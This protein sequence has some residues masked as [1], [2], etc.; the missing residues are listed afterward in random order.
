MYEQPSIHWELAKQRHAMFADEA[1]RAQLAA[2]VKRT[3]W[4]STVL[5]ALRDILPRPTKDV[6]HNPQFQPSV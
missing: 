3:P 1:K 2:Q 5:A 6:A 4:T